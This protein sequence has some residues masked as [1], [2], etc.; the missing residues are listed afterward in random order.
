MRLAP[1]ELARR[2]KPALEQ[3]GLW[4]DAFV[5]DRHA[6]FFAV[7]ELLK[8]RAKRLDDFVEQGRV[9]LSDIVE[10]DEAAVS[11]HLRVDGMRDSLATLDAVFHALETFDPA[12]IEASLRATADA[13]GVK[14][15]SLIHA[16][17]VTV[18]GKTVSP[19]LFEVLAL[20]GRDRVHARINAA[21]RLLS[22]PPS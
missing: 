19:G 10:F 14:P 16:M 9:F 20:L 2:I 5:G 1:G 13:E 11:K 8:P 21:I 3:A 18:T 4:S 6:W 17:R 12:S 7:L 22:A 15:A